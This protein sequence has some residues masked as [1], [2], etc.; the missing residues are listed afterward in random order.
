MFGIL[1]LTL[2]VSDF[3]RNDQAINTNYILK[4]R[5]S[6]GIICLSCVLHNSRRSAGAGRLPS[7]IGATLHR[8]ALF[9][10]FYDN[11]TLAFAEVVLILFQAAGLIFVD[12]TD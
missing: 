5:Y 12:W 2:Q 9:S 7:L 8:V 11:T 10:L 6:P 1:N 4:H 3:P